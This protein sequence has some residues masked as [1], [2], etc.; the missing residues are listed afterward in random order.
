MEEPKPLNLW[1]AAPAAIFLVL[2][3]L[4]LFVDETRTH[5]EVGTSFD[6]GNSGYRAAY[7]LLE[8]LGYP[9]RRLRRLEGTTQ[10]VRWL[11]SPRMRERE[12]AQEHDL[13]SLRHWVERG[14]RLLLATENAA[15][16]NALGIHATLQ[17]DANPDRID[18]VALDGRK[19]HLKGGTV[20]LHLN[21][22]HGPRWLSVDDKP[23]VS[24]HSRGAG[25][26]WVLHYPEMFTNQLVRQSDNAVVLC[27]LAETTLAGRS[28]KI[29][30]DEYFHGMRDRPG[31]FE[32]L[33]TPPVLWITLLG[34]GLLA[35]LVWHNLPRFGVLRPLPPRTR[36]SKEEF[37]DA[38]GTLLHRKG[39]Y[40][41]AYQVVR[42]AL[43]RELAAQLGFPGDTDP[44]VI[45]AAAAQR[46]QLNQD[47]LCLYLTAKKPP[48]GTGPQAFVRALAELEAIRDDFYALPHAR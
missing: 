17:K 3:L 4:T 21:G 47:Q 16:L 22:F 15:L 31:V 25:E 20:V 34:L 23:L 45:A 14:G 8:Q 37:L 19:L 36:R 43:V 35:L 44:A 32:L 7:L 2:L 18:E 33:F 11:L 39:D 30:I 48:G 26:I 27:R 24:I 28:G 12:K 1:W 41:H 29:A 6:P 13:A 40:G 9:V 10:E 46:R 38:M 42:D 5:T